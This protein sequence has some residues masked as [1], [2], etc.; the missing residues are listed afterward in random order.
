VL[1]QVKEFTE[2][3]IGNGQNNLVFSSP[4]SSRSHNKK[5]KYERFIIGYL[6][7]FAATS[8]VFLTVVFDS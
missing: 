6:F 8:T 4:S 7:A 2:T 5:W 1:E 3:E